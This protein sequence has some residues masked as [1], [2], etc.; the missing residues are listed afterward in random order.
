MT[1]TELQSFSKIQKDSLEGIK[2]VNE[3]LGFYSALYEEMMQTNS[4]MG[5][6]TKENKKY[7]VSW[8]YYPSNGLEVMYE[9]K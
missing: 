4:L 5:R 1:L 3:K 6:L 2:F 8:A 9:K 7:R